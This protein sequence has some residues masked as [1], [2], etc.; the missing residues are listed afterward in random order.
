MLVTLATTYFNQGEN[1]AG[2]AAVTEAERLL[3]PDPTA[4]PDLRGQAAETRARLEYS[5]VDYPSADR[6]YQRALAFYA[7]AKDLKPQI[8]ARANVNYGLVLSNMGDHDRARRSFLEGIE[9][10]RR[11]TGERS[12]LTGQAYS[13]LAFSERGAHRL[14]AAKAAI[15]KAIPILAGVLDHDNPI[16]ADALSQRGQILLALDQPAAAATD[17][18]EAIAI[19]ERAYKGPHYKIG[20]IQGY[21]ALA[22]SKLGETKAAL[23]TLEASK[24]NYDAGYKKL[25]PNHG[26]L[27]VQRAQVLQRAGRLTE[28]RAQCVDGLGIIK[29]L[30]GADAS[31]YKEDA[32][33]CAKI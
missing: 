33:I 1:S 8:I 9:I 14:P 18:R 22:Q 25:N 4:R 17:F 19:L 10:Y 29:Q 30:M 27:M 6:D 28:A 20:A 3:G 13:A 23:A 32:G 2:M 7:K 26:D 11:V 12:R 24:A 15:D 16:V 21:L 31:F 5:A